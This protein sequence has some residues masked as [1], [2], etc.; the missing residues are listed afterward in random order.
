MRRTRRND[1]QSPMCDEM[2][3]K[4]VPASLEVPHVKYDVNAEQFLPWQ[5]STWPSPPS[6]WDAEFVPVLRRIFEETI[7][8]ELFN[9]VGDALERTDGTLAH[10][11]HVIAIGLMCAI[12]AASSYAYQS[13]ERDKCKSCKRT[14]SV[15]PRYRRFIS[16][17]FPSEY[18]PYASDLYSLYRNSLVHSWHLFEASMTP[19][20]RPPSRKGQTLHLGLVGLLQALR[21]A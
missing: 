15:G 3:D 1:A 16:E 14:D 10:R 11:G 7:V 4:V 18:R 6:S 5:P 21:V 17:H 2:I 20:E 19:D 13:A 12:D 9:V 8:S